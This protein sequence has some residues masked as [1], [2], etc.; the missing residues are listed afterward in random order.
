MDVVA[1]PSSY[2]LSSLHRRDIAY[3]VRDVSLVLSEL[4]KSTRTSSVQ[5]LC[6]YISAM[7]Q[8]NPIQ[9]PHLLLIRVL[10]AIVRKFGLPKLVQAM[11][12]MLRVESGNVRIVTHAPIF[13]VVMGSSLRVF[14]KCENLLPCDGE[15][16]HI[17]E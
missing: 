4:V 12:L 2:R 17:F 7:P 15:G 14:P 10:L 3:P 16:V 9:L 6:E 8:M 1:Y 5:Y 13:V 11:H